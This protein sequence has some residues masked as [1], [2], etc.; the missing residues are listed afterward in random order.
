MTNVTDCI[1]CVITAKKEVEDGLQELWRW[2]IG[3]ITTALDHIAYA[4]HWTG[5]DKRTAFQT[6]EPIVSLLE[7]VSDRPWSTLNVDD[8]LL[9]K[10][11]TWEIVTTR[12][13]YLGCFDDQVKTLGYFS[14]SV[15]VPGC[16]WQSRS[17]SGEELSVTSGGTIGPSTRP[18]SQSNCQMSVSSGSSTNNQGEL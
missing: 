1:T 5:D 10:L 6:T 9:G 7:D 14:R 15:K 2:I 11:G 4:G 16:Y 17:R 18:R 13:K 3:D 12:E 8:E